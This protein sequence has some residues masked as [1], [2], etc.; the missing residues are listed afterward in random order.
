MMNEWFAKQ[1][2][3]VFNKDEQDFLKKNHLLDK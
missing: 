3:K 2:R 1:I